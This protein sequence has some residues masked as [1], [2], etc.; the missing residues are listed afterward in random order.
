MTRK[1]CAAV[2]FTAI[3]ALTA[4]ADVLRSDA[5]LILWELEIEGNTQV[6]TS[7]IRDSIESTPSSHLTFFWPIFGGRREFDPLAFEADKKRIEHL[8]Q[9]KGFLRAAVDH[10]EAKPCPGE[11]ATASRIRICARLHIDE[12]GRTRVAEVNTRVIDGN[13]EPSVTRINEAF[14]IHPG[15]DFDH[16]RYQEGKKNI[17]DA[18]QEDAY[19]VPKLTGKI[20]FDRDPNTVAIDLDVTPG[21]TARIG[22]ISFKGLKDVLPEDAMDRLSIKTGMDFDPATFRESS[23]LLSQLDVFRSVEAEIKPREDNPHIADVT[24][25][26]AE[27]P[28][29][30][31][32]FGGGFRIDNS[33]QDFH[34]RSEWTHRNF[35][36]HLRTF[37]VRVEPAYSWLPSLFH[38]DDSGPLGTADVSLHHPAFLGPRLDL[39]TGIGFIA[40]L[41]QG[42]RWYGPNL[43]GGIERKFLRTLLLSTGYTFR[44]LTFYHVTIAP[45]PTLGSTIP[46]ELLFSPN[47]RLGFFDQRFIWDNRDDPQ[48]SRSGAFT[49]LALAEGAK[50]LGGSYS[51]FRFAP[52][53]RG[54]LPLSNRLSLAARVFYGRIVPLIDQSTPITERLYGGGAS[55]HRGFAYHRLSP[56]VP[57]TT[58]ETVPIGGAV[59]FLSSVESRV[60]LFQLADRWIIG[61]VFLDMGDVVPSETVL[62]LGRLNNAVGLGFRYNSILGLVRADAGFRLNRT[63]DFTDGLPNP[64][65]GKTFA[66]HISLGEA[67]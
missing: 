46:P 35:H 40:D 36:H 5:Q 67:I 27:R 15:N 64:D 20:N 33:R 43:H 6:P 31:L 22:L 38:P 7:V 42:Y 45:Q 28:P 26:V 61:A 66:F 16:D 65:P 39:R 34:L 52:E 4:R 41:E 30:T 32:Q 18:L 17:L 60:R 54:Y 49:Q 23:E 50:F 55:D 10:A 3:A 51:Y 21:S 58:G 47:Y 13:P 57:S 1:I 62:D 14:G 11:D 19:P 63:S 8:Y 44:Y 9:R 56:M 37:N 48:E 25:Y 2:A 24:Y 12:G 29:K 59:E 53:V